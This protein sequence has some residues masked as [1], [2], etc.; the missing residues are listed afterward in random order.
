MA[1]ESLPLLKLT[2]RLR[3]KKENVVEQVRLVEDYVN[4]SCAQKEKLTM[5]YDSECNKI[6]QEFDLAKEVLERRKSSILKQIEKQKEEQLELMSSQ[7]NLAR[8]AVTRAT[9]VCLVSRADI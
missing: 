5:K 2:Q 7:I 4:T 8:V 1:E 9:Q 6:R 3:D